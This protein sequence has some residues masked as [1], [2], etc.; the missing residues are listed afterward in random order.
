MADFRLVGKV[1]AANLRSPRAHEKKAVKTREEYSALGGR[2]RGFICLPCQIL[3]TCPV[4][5]HIIALE[6]SVMLRGISQFL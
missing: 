4:A 2:G 1:T 6:I 3:L 5:Q